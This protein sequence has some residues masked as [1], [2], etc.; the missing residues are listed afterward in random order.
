MSKEVKQDVHAC[1]RAVMKLL[2]TTGISK[3]S[4]NE[5]QRFQFRGIDDALNAL[6]GPLVA[7]GLVIYPTV[8]SV[9]RTERTTKSGNSMTNTLLVVDYRLVSVHDGSE[10]VVTFAGEASDSGDKG[11]SKALSMSLKYAL[12]QTFCI[13]VIGMD[14][15]DSTTPPPSLPVKKASKAPSSPQAARKSAP[16][17][18]VAPEEN[19]APEG[20]QEP[21]TPFT[22]EAAMEALAAVSTADELAALRPKLAAF[23]KHKSFSKMKELFVEVTAKFTPAVEE[24]S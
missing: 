22:F 24:R 19:E 5:Q 1:V 17:G 16:A 21:E 18:E 2:G 6:N 20:S 11:V 9:E 4:V 12:F 14:D 10:M 8:R 3:D 23:S 7:A 13:P 15:S